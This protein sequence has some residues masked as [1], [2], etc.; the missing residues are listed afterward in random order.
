MN[1]KMFLV[2]NKYSR[3][4]IFQV[5]G[6]TPEPTGGNWFTGYTSYNGEHF[7]FVNVDTAGRTGHF[8]GD[9]WQ[10]DG[11]LYWFGT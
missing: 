5:L 11:T 8:Y 3:K 10:E 2:G 7:V 4:D 9:H 6:I 1:G